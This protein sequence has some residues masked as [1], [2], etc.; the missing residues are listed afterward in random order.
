MSK[1]YDARCRLLPVPMPASWQGSMKPVSLEEWMPDPV[2]LE[3]RS[4]YTDTNRDARYERQ[5]QEIRQLRDA[6]DQERKARNVE[7]VENI[8]REIALRFEVL[9]WR[10]CYRLSMIFIASCTILAFLILLYE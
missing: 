7:C 4:R 9:E 8:R 1:Q 6:L 2:P 5:E 3:S 10:V